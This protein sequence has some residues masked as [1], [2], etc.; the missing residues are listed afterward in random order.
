MTMRKGE[1]KSG[2]KYK[3]DEA[4]L[5]DMELIDAMAETDSGNP[6]KVSV[7]VDKLLGAEQKQKLYDHLRTKKGNVPIQEVVDTVIEIF[8]DMGEQG[9][10]S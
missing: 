1:T 3:V 4:M 9:K 8:E 5:D 6:L 7:V 2:F 10:N